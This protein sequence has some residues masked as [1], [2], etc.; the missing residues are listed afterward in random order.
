MASRSDLSYGLVRVDPAKV[1]LASVSRIPRCEGIRVVEL[2]LAERV[3]DRC[4][5]MQ[6]Q[7]PMSP[8]QGARCLENAGHY[9]PG[10]GF[11][12]VFGGEMRAACR[13]TTETNC[14]IRNIT[15]RRGNAGEYLLSL[16]IRP[17]GL[18]DP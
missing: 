1:P 4:D 17:S 14:V 18:R 12:L 11:A 10:S 9:D 6:P 15:R 16:F 3:V 13:I 8:A 7:V 2:E 5:A